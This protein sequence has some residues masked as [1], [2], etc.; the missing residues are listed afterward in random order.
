[1]VHNYY[2]SPSYQATPLSSSI[3]IVLNIRPDNI[4]R[5]LYHTRALMQ[6]CALCL[7]VWEH[8]HTAHDRLDRVRVDD[9]FLDAGDEEGRLATLELIIKVDEEGEKRGLSGIGG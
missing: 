9:A 7:T 4:L 2:Q 5:T 1:M 6:Q 8:R 3:D